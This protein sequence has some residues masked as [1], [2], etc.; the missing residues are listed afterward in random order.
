LHRISIVGTSCSGKT[1]L[2]GRLAR[3]LDIQHVELD[4]IFHLPD[5]RERDRSE[6]REIVARHASRDQWVIDGNYSVVRDIVWLRATTIIFLDLDFPLVMRRAL[7]RT[8]RRFWTQEP[9]C[10]D[11]RETLRSIFGPDG[12]PLW[13]IRTHRRNR[14]RYRELLRQDG[15]NGLCLIVLHC[16]QSVEAFC[17]R[18]E[19]EGWRAAVLAA[20]NRQPAAGRS[21]RE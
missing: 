20:R 19:A 16:E 17:R 8:L 4:A 15:D 13:V 5:W 12:I 11:N 6:F 7:A 14:L 1:T 9:V 18:V 2:A 3:A 10:G 21:V